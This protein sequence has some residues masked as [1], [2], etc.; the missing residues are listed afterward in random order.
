MGYINREQLRPFAMDKRILIDTL[1]V[2]VV[3]HKRYI[4]PGS[5]GDTFNFVASPKSI[6]IY[7]RT[8]SHYHVGAT[9]DESGM[10]E[11]RI[12]TRIQENFDP[13]PDL[14]AKLFYYATM[15]YLMVTMNN[16]I[17]IIE[18]EWNSGRNLREYRQAIRDHKTPTQAVFLTWNGR[19]ALEYGFNRCTPKS[20]TGLDA[21]SYKFWL[22][23]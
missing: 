16:P 8:D 14:Y 19:K 6:D 9:L 4:V 12:Y 17:S 3:S 7:S 20:P 23:R 2:E 11:W 10:L 22:T 5:S 15:S 21:Y 18:E 1:P 13:H